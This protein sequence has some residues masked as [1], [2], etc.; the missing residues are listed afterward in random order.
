MKILYSPST[1]ASFNIAT[2]EYLLKN[3][4]DDIFYLYVNSPSI[5]VGRKQNTIAE[6]N[7]DFITENDIPVVRRMSGG[8]AVFHDLG[9]LNFCFIIRNYTN[10]ENDFARY[11]KPIIDV[12][13]SLGVDAKLEGRN[14]L[15]ID[16]KKFSGNAKYHT[17][18][19]LLQHGTLLFTSKL[20]DLS[21]ALKADP[22]K[23]NDKAVK[24]IQSR[25]TNISEHLPTPISLDDFTKKL[26]DHIISIYSDAEY[27][28][29]TS[30]DKQHIQSLVDD[31]Y[32]TWDWN[33]GKSP[34]YNYTKS[35]RTS[36]GTL[37]VSMVVKNGMIKNI[38]FFGD[39]FST[40]DIDIY[41]KY[42]ENTSHNFGEILKL[43]VTYPP[44]DY[45][46]NIYR[47][48]LLNVFF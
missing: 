18:K 7:Y 33:F 17:E 5:I 10:V 45:F 30:E 39:F 25:V 43:L 11:T 24:S 38:R 27:Y 41:E 31:K 46:I 36:G 20:S 40:K 37:Q 15:T 19:T 47:E 32:G 35:I 26:I 21:K 42:F 6:I 28:D 48:D 44:E 3:F 14:D 34:E 23:F 12:L 29:T 13:Q 4:S 8:G 2:E 1:Y 9:N 22:E 16:G